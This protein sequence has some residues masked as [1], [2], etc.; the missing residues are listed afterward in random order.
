MGFMHGVILSF[1]KN[2][3]GVDGGWPRHV[4]FSIQDVA[5]LCNGERPGPLGKSLQNCH[6]IIVTTSQRRHCSA[7]NVAS[8][9]TIRIQ[10]NNCGERRMRKFVAASVLGTAAAGILS[11]CGG[12]NGY[13]GSN[14]G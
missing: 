10:R 9:R 8:I 2:H 11:A 5:Y 14:N 7:V 4:A 12:G 1:S 13:G 6:R 3:D